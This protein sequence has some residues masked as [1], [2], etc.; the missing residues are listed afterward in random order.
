MAFEALMQDDKDRAEV[1]GQIFQ[2][3]NDK[4]D[5]KIIITDPEKIGRKDLVTYIKDFEELHQ[6]QVV[7]PGSAATVIDSNFGLRPVSSDEAPA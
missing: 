5:Q 7:T 3:K 4:P 6:G 1:N 2:Y